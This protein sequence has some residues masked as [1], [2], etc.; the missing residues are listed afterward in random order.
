MMESFS[1][2]DFREGVDSF[3]QRRAPQFERLPSSAAGA[4]QEPA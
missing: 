3:T 4:Q 2:H 1:R